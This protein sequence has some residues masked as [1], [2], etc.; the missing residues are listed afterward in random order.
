VTYRLN[1]KVLAEK[2]LAERQDSYDHLTVKPYQ[3]TSS[4]EVID[5]RFT[6]INAG[7]SDISKHSVVCISKSIVTV[8]GVIFEHDIFHEQPTSYSFAG[9]E[10]AMARPFSACLCWL[11]ARSPARTWLSLSS[12]QSQPNRA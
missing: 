6:V 11:R 9:W 4:E 3:L 7:R 2:R 10:V 5:T 1:A 12:F 8:S